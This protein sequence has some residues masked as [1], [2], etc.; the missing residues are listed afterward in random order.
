MRVSELFNT[1]LFT[2]QQEEE[3]V[4]VCQLFNTL[5]FTQQQQ[6]EEQEVRVS[7]LFT[8]EENNSDDDVVGKEKRLKKVRSSYAEV[9][10]NKTAEEK[11]DAVS[12]FINTARLTGGRATFMAG[13]SYYS[14]SYYDD[15][16]SALVNCKS[17]LLLKHLRDFIDH[18]FLR[19]VVD[20][21]DDNEIVTFR[22]LLV[23]YFIYH[24]IRGCFDNN[25][26]QNILDLFVDSYY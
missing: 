19:F 22:L 14:V 21:D 16:T 2:Q 3:E 5:L 24:Q 7:Q 9:F 20:D 4:R 25:M 8:M 1:L 12:A 23:L 18:Y 13:F 15:D 11:V 6:Q 17:I 10:F 26:N